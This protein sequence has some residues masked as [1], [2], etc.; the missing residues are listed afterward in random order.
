MIEPTFYN[1]NITFFYSNKVEKQTIK[2][3]A[4]EA[5]SRGYEVVY[6][7]NPFKKAVIGVYCQHICFPRNASFSLIMLHDLGQGQLHW[8]NMWK[9]EPWNDFDV[10]ILPGKAWSDRW[11]QSSDHVFAHPRQGVFE[12]GWPKADVYFKNIDESQKKI[13]TFK[14][15]LNLPYDKS[16]LYAPAWENDDKQLKCVEQLLTSGVN[17]L[18]KQFPWDHNFPEMVKEVE[19]VNLINKDQA[20]HIKVIDPEINIFDCLSIAD[21]VVSEE[22]SVL[23]EAVLMDKPAISVSDWLIPDTTPPRN[24]NA[25]F[26]SVIKILNDELADTVK[27]IFQRIEKGE[28]FKYLKEKEFSMIGESSNKIM[29]L[30]DDFVSENNTHISKV[31]GNTITIKYPF[32]DILKSILRHKVFI[33]KYML[34]RLKS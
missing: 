5:I 19:R 17:I 32:L 15:S 16:V 18:L 11:K 21:I 8:P 27:D 28:D 1:K 26:D 23:L 30:I 3:V 4:D 10:G 9:V 6:T 24:P 25:P 34:K 12:L 2:P 22:S 13:L 14:K 33:I 31:H 7:D 20:N 29:D